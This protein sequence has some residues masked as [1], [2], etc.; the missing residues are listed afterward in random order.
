MSSSSSF[1]ATALRLASVA[2]LLLLC[3]SASPSVLAEPSHPPEE[4]SDAPAGAAGAATATSAS[5]KDLSNVL[6]FTPEQVAAARQQLNDTARAVLAAAE[7]TRA[8]KARFFQDA[9]ATPFGQLKAGGLRAGGLVKRTNRTSATNDSGNWLTSELALAPFVTKAFDQV[10]AAVERSPVGKAFAAKSSA[11][12]PASA[13]STEASSSSS[14]SSSSDSGG[15]G[16]SASRPTLANLLPPLPPLP[17]APG[18]VLARASGGALPESGPVE[19]LASAVSQ[20]LK[21]AAESSVKS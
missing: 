7:A 15:S 16:S 14:G 11:S 3:T 6:T 2:L 13:D 8:A 18:K 10:S 9:I 17:T 5:A 4:A 20:G 21:G 19:D 12:E 1:V